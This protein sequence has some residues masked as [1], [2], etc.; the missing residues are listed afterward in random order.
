MFWKEQNVTVKFISLSEF[1]FHRCVVL[2]WLVTPQIAKRSYVEAVDTCGQLDAV[3]LEVDSSQ[4]RLN[5]RY[6]HRRFNEAVLHKSAEMMMDNNVTE[7]KAFLLKRTTTFWLHDR[8]FF[9][10]NDSDIGGLCSIFR[11]AGPP[12]SAVKPLSCSDKCL[13]ETK[14]RHVIC[15]FDPKVEPFEVEGRKRCINANFPTQPEERELKECRNGLI[16]R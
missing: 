2:P 6:S 14:V 12:S 8:N 7:L 9:R 11:F 4:P 15:E 10:V 16:K 13:V 5:R 1:Q 3:I